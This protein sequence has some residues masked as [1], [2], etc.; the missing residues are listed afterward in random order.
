MSVAVETQSLAAGGFGGQ[1]GYHPPS[2]MNN[3]FNKYYAEQT[4]R[5]LTGPTNGIQDS[6][7][8]NPENRN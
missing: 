4:S 6:S 7:F 1:L 3:A 2:F 8:A 5:L